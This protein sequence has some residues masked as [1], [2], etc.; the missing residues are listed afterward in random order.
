MK[1][2]ILYF[3]GTGNTD[4]VARYL[5]R[6]LAVPDLETVLWSVE[7]ERTADLADFDVLALGFPVY[8]AD[9]PGFLQE[10][11]HEMSPGE[12]RGAYVFCT[13]GAVAGNAVR[14]NLQRLAERGYVPLGGASVGMPGS[15]GLAFSRTGSWM[16]RAALEKDFD[17]LHT[18]DRL[19]G[20]MRTAL[21]G[22]A[23]GE[24]VEAYHRPLPLSVTGVLVD[25]LWSALYVAFAGYLRNK[26]LADHQC[27]SCGLCVRLCPVGAVELT[28]GRP[29]FDEECALCMRCIHACPQEAIQFGRATA[30]KFRWHGPKGDF[31]PQAL[32][33]PSGRNGESG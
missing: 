14:R 8:A 30:G 31:R 26:L 1:L 6:R 16:A 33:P 21:S 5:A 17:H 9:A 27:I 20:R 32:R 12:G 24:P 28:D 13:K 23:H 29:R 11:L 15:D 19:A 3:S 18:V 4:Y 22:M 2:A 25:W 7:R 10:F